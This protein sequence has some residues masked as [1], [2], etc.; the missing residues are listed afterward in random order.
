[1]KKFLTF[2]TG[3]A[4]FMLLAISCNKEPMPTQA[5]ANTQMENTT[6]LTGHVGYIGERFGGGII[7]YINSSGKHG[8]IADTVD[9]PPA[10]WNNLKSIV[11]GATAFD[12][13]GGKANTRKII[14]AQGRTG[15]YAALECAR[16]TNSGYTDWFLPSLYE[17]D[18]LQNQQD[19]VGG[20]T[21]TNYWSSTE[22]SQNYSWLKNFKAGWHDQTQKG[23]IASVR[24]IRYY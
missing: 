12:I 3:L 11:T 4:A 13:G 18:Q 10:S 2:K 24:A 7:F 20:F 16:S 23:Y 8:M 5:M 1:M 9:L 21:G 19:V 6:V 15:N 22:G 17:L 14:L